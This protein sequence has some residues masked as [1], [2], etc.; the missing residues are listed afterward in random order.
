MKTRILFSIS[1]SILMTGL[2]LLINSCK[3]T[4]SEHQ[5]TDCNMTWKVDGIS[6]TGT[7]VISD[8]SS[9]NSFFLIDG[10][11]P[12][13]DCKEVHLRICSPGIGDFSLA[14]HNY[15]GCNSST[16]GSGYSEYWDGASISNHSTYITDS[17]R[18]G[19]LTI[20]KYDVITKKVSG[21]FSFTAIKTDSQGTPINGG[22]TV[23]IQGTLTD[24]S[25]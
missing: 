2:L 17:T 12:G 6:Y 16:A 4:E 5:C 25:F 3:K 15:S 9:I 7:G 14:T 1:I 21:T 10:I 20:T 8:L 24:V 19:T 18:T 22:T 23:T 11:A 13:S